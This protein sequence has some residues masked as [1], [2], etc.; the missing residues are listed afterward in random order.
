MTP[1]EIVGLKMNPLREATRNLLGIATTKELKKWLKKNIKDLDLSRITHWNKQ[2]LP[3]LRYKNSWQV[4]AVAI[5]K[6]LQNAKFHSSQKMFN[7]MNLD[8]LKRECRERDIHCNIEPTKH[9]L[10]SLLIADELRAS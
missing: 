10:K 2:K 9:N 8:E 7:R 1:S 5:I 3:D 6:W 4:L